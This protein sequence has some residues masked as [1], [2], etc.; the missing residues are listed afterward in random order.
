MFKVGQRA[1][2]RKTVT[3]LDVNICAGLMG[4]FN[5]IHI[6]EEAVKDSV[7]GSRIAHGMLSVGFISGIL[8]TKFPGEGRIY[9]GQTLQFLKPVYIGDIITAIC[10]IIEILNLI[11]GIYKLRTVCKNQNNEIVVDGEAVVKNTTDIKTN[12][13]KSDDENRNN[14]FYSQSELSRLGLKSYGLNVL[15]SRNA[16]LYQPELLEIG[17]NVRIDGFTTISGKV[18]LGDYIHIAQFCGLY[19]G[20]EGIFMEDFSGLS[21]RIVI[22][23]TSDDYSGK[24]LTNPAVPEKY[25]STDKNYPVKFEKLRAEEEFEGAACKF[26]TQKYEFFHQTEECAA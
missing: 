25:R 4:D 3:E 20:N 12:D 17:N 15:I 7:F 22:Y 1:T 8:G 6:N 9:L 21:S 16:V 24:S 11:K 5:Q 26:L 19:G 14:S 18:V 13:D 23:A 10:Q 2:F